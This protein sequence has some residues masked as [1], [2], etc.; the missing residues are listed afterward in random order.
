MGKEELLLSGLDNSSCE[1]ETTLFKPSLLKSI[2][3]KF[4]SKALC[5]VIA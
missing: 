5:W 3:N 1:F 2:I 4:T